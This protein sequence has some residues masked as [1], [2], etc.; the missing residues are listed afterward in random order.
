MYYGGCIIKPLKWR[1]DT[2]RSSQEAYAKALLG[3]YN[4]ILPN[5]IN[6][7]EKNIP[8]TVGDR[9]VIVAYLRIVSFFSVP[10]F[11]RLMFSLCF[12]ITKDEIIAAKIVVIH[13]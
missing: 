12:Q 1:D 7:C 6:A 3:L 11:N 5:G 2:I 13:T 9:K 8:K 10:F 4:R